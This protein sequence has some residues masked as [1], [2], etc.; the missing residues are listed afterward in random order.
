[1]KTFYVN[2]PF[3][4]GMMEIDAETGEMIK[5][6]PKKKSE[7]G[8]MM[9]DALKKLEDDK[10]KREGLFDRRKT[11]IED[12]KKRAED[13]FRKGVDKVKKE[14]LGEAPPTPFDLD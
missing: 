2:C 13:L 9:G 6:W 11:E 10:K 7:S 12:Q 5:K 1:M 8:D 14:G 4:E 3:C